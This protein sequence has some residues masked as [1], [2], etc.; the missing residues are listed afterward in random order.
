MGSWRKAKPRQ[1]KKIVYALNDNTINKIIKDHEDRGWKK[2]SEVKDY[3]YGLG[4]LMIYEHRR[5][6]D[7]KTK[8]K[9][10]CHR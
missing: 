6:K 4:C 2:A 10:D 9:S 1:L 3:I 8:S 7:A 5:E